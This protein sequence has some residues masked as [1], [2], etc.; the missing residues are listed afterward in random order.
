MARIDASPKIVRTREHHRSGEQTPPIF[1]P[2]PYTVEFWGLLDHSDTDQ[3]EDRHSEH[4]ERETTGKRRPLPARVFA[5]KSCRTP[6]TSH[7][8]LPSF[9]VSC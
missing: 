5:S 2:S 1:R 6:R 4:E 3:E 8:P 7:T 9:L